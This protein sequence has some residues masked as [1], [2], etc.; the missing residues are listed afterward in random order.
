MSCQGQ[1]KITDQEMYTK[2]STT[3]NSESQYAQFVSRLAVHIN[4][5]ITLVM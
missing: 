2:Q 5:Y 3:I 4:L 1:I